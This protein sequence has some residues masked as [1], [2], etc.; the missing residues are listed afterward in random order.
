MSYTNSQKQARW[1]QRRK[2]RTEAADEELK[3]A[4]ARIAELESKQ[5]QANPSNPGE[6]AK[7]KDRNATLELEAIALKQA[8]QQA[9]AALT[10]ARSASAKLTKP[11]VDPDSELARQLKGERTKNTNLRREL[12]V[13]KD[14]Y[15]KE[16]L[17]KGKMSL[18]T[19]RTIAKC[20]HPDRTP[21]VEER[22]NAMK[23]FND[24]GDRLRMTD[25]K[26]AVKP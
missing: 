11:P 23:L 14:W 5:A 21:S 18:S 26:P 10:K 16:L 3:K 9:Q 19:F 15:A 25:P 20:L 17:R 12:A 8:L 22:E 24:L 1:R 6:L 4:Q 7:L 2:A 13:M